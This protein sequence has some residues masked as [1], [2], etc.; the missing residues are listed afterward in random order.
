MNTCDHKVMFLFIS[1]IFKN[2]ITD[3][4]LHI[5][6]THVMNESNQEGTHEVKQQCVSLFTLE[7]RW[8]FNIKKNISFTF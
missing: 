4:Q 2:Q 6:K 3:N 1:G 7:L 5:K 8:A